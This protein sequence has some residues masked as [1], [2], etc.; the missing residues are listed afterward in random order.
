LHNRDKLRG[1]LGEDLSKGLSINNFDEIAPR[2]GL[3]LDESIENKPRP[4][5]A[6]LRF[7]RL[8]SVQRWPEDLDARFQSY[9]WTGPNSISQR[10]KRES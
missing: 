10:K 3:D 9:L 7:F 4:S 2:F 1:L 6:M 5:M 8:R